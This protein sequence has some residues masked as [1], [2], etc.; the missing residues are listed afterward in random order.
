LGTVLLIQDIWSRKIR[1][2]DERLNHL[3]TD[4]PE[5]QGQAPKIVETMND[6]DSIIRSR[7]DSQVEMFYKHYSSTPVTTK[8]LCVVLKVL[9]DD[10]FIITSYFTNTVK[11]GEVIW[12]KK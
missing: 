5:M 1:L 7:I 2:T 10:N 3:E 6:P 8:F 12:E 11:K 9:L 4:H